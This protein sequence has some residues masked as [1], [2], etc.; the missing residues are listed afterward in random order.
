MKLIASLLL[1][2]LTSAESEAKIPRSKS[3][4]AE[5]QRLN[6]CPTTGKRTGA[7][8]GYVKDHIKPLCAGGEDA[9]SNMQW[10]TVEEAKAKDVLERRECR[11]LKKRANQ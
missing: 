3:V 11:A 2:F 8:P 10:Q 5:F 7:C 1:L 6:P 4:T 9:V